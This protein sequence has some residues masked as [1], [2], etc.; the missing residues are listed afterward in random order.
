MRRALERQR[1]IL[2]FTLSSL[3]RRRGRN[4][5]LLIVYTLVVFLLASVLFLAAAL[6]REAALILADTPDLI[7]QR[8]TAG[9]QDLVPIR[10][11]ES[12][13]RI[14]GV[15]AVEPRLWGYYFDGLSGATYTLMVSAALA[16]HPGAILI[17]GGVSRRS[18]PGRPAR[19]LGKGDVLPFRD[20]DGG[21]LPLRVQGVFPAASALVTA[22]LVLV[23]AT[24]FRRLFAFPDGQATDLVVRVRNA[25]ERATVAAK[26][27]RLHQDSR[28]VLRDDILRTYEAVFDWRGGVI[29]LVLAG[30]LLAF[31]I[32]AWD[33]ATGLSAEERREIGILK[34]IGW[35]TSDVLL[36][37]FWEGAAVSLCAFFLG[38]FLAYLHVFFTS[39]LLFEPFLK[40]WSVLY[41]RFRLTPQV[42]LGQLAVLFVLTVVPY[43][44]A[45]IVP[46][47]RSATIDPDTVMRR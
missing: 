35:E 46:S 26:I 13:A 1:H 25:R 7:V 24:D 6:K 10:Y 5:A 16:D 38:V 11:V 45:T 32:L 14:R 42:Q 29:V 40:G 15:Q 30:A 21:V 2:D 20:A 39:S 33:K 22:D 23:S 12:I 4:L 18:E 9:R 28:P 27:S 36:M 44:V 8:L 34:A 31:V 41:P 17:G 47:W 37:K 43:T 19:P 3:A